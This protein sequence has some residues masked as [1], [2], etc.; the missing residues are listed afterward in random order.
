MLSEHVDAG[1]LT[2]A[3]TPTGSEQGVAADLGIYLQAD[4]V[5]MVSF[6]PAE[7]TELHPV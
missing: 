7:G 3:V 2:I 6:D 5:V 1:A 4:R